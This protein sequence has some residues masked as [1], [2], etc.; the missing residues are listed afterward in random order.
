LRENN[1]AIVGWLQEA[2]EGLTEAGTNGGAV[3]Y[4]S[5]TWG[6]HIEGDDDENQGLLS[7]A[8]S[9]PFDFTS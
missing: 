7:G 2:V 5:G 4:K 1:E 9:N 6:E 8:Q 3:G